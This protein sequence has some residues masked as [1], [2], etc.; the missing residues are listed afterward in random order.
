[1]DPVTEHINDSI[2][3]SKMWAQYWIA[4]ATTGVA[5]DRRLYHGTGVDEPFT[6]EEKVA[7]A[8]QSARIHIHNMRELVDKKIG[9]LSKRGG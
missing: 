7:E 1:M 5:K 9:I 3:I 4:M 6:D 2:E 8:L